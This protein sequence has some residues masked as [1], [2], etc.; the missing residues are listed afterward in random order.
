MTFFSHN[1]F[2]PA[3]GATYYFATVPNPS[4][5]TIENFGSTQA[6]DNFT[7]KKIRGVFTGAAASAQ[8]VSFYLTVEGVDTLIETVQLTS[9]RVLIGN[10]AMNVAVTENQKMS[11]KMVCPT[12]TSPPTNVTFSF[13]LS[14]I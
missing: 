13:N 9:T 4:P 11:I 5:Q 6:P 1:R 7:V 2:N 14:M 3:S 8:N 10:G 12:W